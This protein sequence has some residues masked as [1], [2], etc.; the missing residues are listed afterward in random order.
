[1]LD[2]N[3]VPKKFLFRSFAPQKVNSQEV[4][5]GSASP[6][7]NCDTWRRN[8]HA[9]HY[10]MK[11]N[12][13]R[14]KKTWKTKT[15]NKIDVHLRVKNCFNRSTIKRRW[16]YAKMTSKK[17]FKRKICFCCIKPEPS[18]NAK[19]SPRWEF[20]GFLVLSISPTHKHKKK[21]KT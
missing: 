10:Q 14:P 21:H 6:C 18:F 11:N 17:I 2:E 20:E 12:C 8:F 15:I 4:S 7:G 19:H 5:R 16:N 1:M 13:R 9:K 3:F